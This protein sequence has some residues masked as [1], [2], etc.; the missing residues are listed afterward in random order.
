MITSDLHLGHKN[1]VKF[2]DGFSSEDHHHEVMFENL[3]SSI[4]KRDSLILLGDIA[5]NKFWLE[6]IKSIKCVKKTLICGNHD[7]ENGIKM[8]DLVEVYDD[9]HSLFSKR[10]VWFS[11]CPIHS[12]QFRGKAHNIHGHLHD[13]KVQK[14]GIV[15]GKVH[16]SEIE[17]YTD[18]N[19]YLNACV[20][21]TNYKPISFADLIKK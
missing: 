11:H 16:P 10:N 15:E 8:R 2:R 9:I 19:R 14:I 18:D 20:E 17:A 21:H 3:A 6:Q 1:I 4:Q 5:F 12:S 7:T 13:N